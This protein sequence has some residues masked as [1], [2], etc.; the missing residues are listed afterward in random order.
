MAAVPG[1]LRRWNP[2]II[3]G[4]QFWVDPT[5]N[6]SISS[7]TNGT[8]NSIRDK[9]ANRVLMAQPTDVNQPTMAIGQSG[10]SVI[11]FGTNLYL[12]TSNFP[13]T[14]SN[15]RPISQISVFNLTLETGYYNY[16]SYLRGNVPGEF[17]SIY[18]DIS[19][20][21]YIGVP[22]NTAPIYN[23]SITTNTVITEAFYNS[24]GGNIA[25][26]YILYNSDTPNHSF[27]DRTQPS[28]VGPYTNRLSN[29]TIGRTF[30]D[31]ILNP[32]QFNGAMCEL[33]FYNNYHY[34]TLY[35]RQLEG[36]L[37]WKWNITSFL[38]SDHPYKNRPP[39]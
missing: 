26:G 3:P 7:N 22:P 33:I 2:G 37:A 6:L 16:F 18:T 29:L 14:F 30:F 34:D 8:V 24:S 15:S 31:T 38:P 5:D 10:N 36:Y 35:M 12:E 23:P 21:I 19:D 28:D 13:A 25:D 39:S 17:I 20:H 4:L 27:D 11:Q 9:S 32:E 1:I